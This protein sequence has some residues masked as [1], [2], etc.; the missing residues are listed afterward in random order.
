MPKNILKKFLVKHGEMKANVKM[1]IS[2]A[3]LYVYRYTDLL[4]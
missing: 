2:I 3:I 4:H 1:K